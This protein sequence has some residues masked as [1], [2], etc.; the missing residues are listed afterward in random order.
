[1]P[2]F[3]A[4]RKV[5]F[6]PRQMFDVV[7]DVER[8]PLFLPLCE[9]LTVQERRSLE[10]RTELTATMSVGYGAIQE[11]F[12]TRVTLD[13]D[14]GVI[15]VRNLDGPFSKLENTW[16]FVPAPGGCEV[17]FAIDYEFRSMMLSL[18]AGAA[19]EKA[20]R[21]YTEAFEQRARTLYGPPASV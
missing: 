5:A 6:T 12:T 3:R 19:F 21:S 17:Q 4:V 2:S 7:A 20:A 1:V 18:V 10:G 11:A 15:H 8:Y 16:R 9:G 13:A 14:G